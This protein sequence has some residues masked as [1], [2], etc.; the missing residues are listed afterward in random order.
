MNC[1]RLAAWFER[2]WHEPDSSVLNRRDGCRRQRT[3]HR[4]RAHPPHLR[5][6]LH[7]EGD[8]ARR[9]RASDCRSHTVSF[10]SMAA[11][12]RFSVSPAAALASIWSFLLRKGD[13]V[14]GANRCRRSGSP[15]LFENACKACE[16]LKP[17]GDPRS[18]CPEGTHI[19]VIDDEADI[20]ESLE[21]LLTLEGYSV[22]L[23]PNATEGLR[24][25]DSRGYDMV[26]LDLMMP[27]RSGSGGSALKFASAIRRLRSFSSPLTARSRLPSKRSRPAQTIISP[28]P[29]T[30]KSC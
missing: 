5:S 1:W 26:L 8:R 27:D 7:D 18:P 2:S 22:D 29:V 15:R 10:R 23:A 6:L 14:T 3:R 25:L 20:R 30:T 19:L 28:S 13:K 9:A 12:S 16:C 21:T 4:P 24:A 11:P 17:P